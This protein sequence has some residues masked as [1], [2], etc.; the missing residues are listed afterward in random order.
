MGGI[1]F[2]AQGEWVNLANQCK[3]CDHPMPLPGME[4]KHCPECG[5]YQEKIRKAKRQPDF[6][7]CRN[8]QAQCLEGNR[9]CIECGKLL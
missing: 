5:T 2:N 6:I 9:H 8:C 1:G 4:N 3:K 7:V